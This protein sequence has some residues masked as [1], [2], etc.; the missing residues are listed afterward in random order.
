M[1]EFT[2]KN[3][4]LQMWANLWKKKKKIEEGIFLNLKLR[5]RCHRGSRHLS[6]IQL[7]VEV[8]RLTNRLREVFKRYLHIKTRACKQSNPD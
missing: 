6:L 8:K 2:W 5:S 3:T 7:S 4:I 1:K